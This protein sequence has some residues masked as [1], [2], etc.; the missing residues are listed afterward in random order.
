LLTFNNYWTGLTY[1]FLVVFLAF[2]LVLM[3]FYRY[4]LIVVEELSEFVSGKVSLYV[5]VFLAAVSVA[6][7]IQTDNFW[8]TV[9]ASAFAPIAVILILTFLIRRLKK[10]AKGEGLQHKL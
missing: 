8:V 2:I 4:R 3:F 6:F 7:I 10:M 5:S 9:T 1:T